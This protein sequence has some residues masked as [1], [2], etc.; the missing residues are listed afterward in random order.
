MTIKISDE[1]TVK[2]KLDALINLNLVTRTYVFLKA[3]KRWLVWLY[4]NGFLD[5]IIEEAKEFESTRYDLPEMDYLIRMSRVEPEKAADILVK[6]IAKMP[7]K[8]I[9]DLVFMD[10]L[11]I[12]AIM[13]AAQLSVILEAIYSTRW[14]SLV[15]IN[16]SSTASMHYKSIFKKL[17]AAKCSEESLRLAEEI[18]AV[19]KKGKT[20]KQN[21]YLQSGDDNFY[22]T[23]LAE[24]GVFHA[25]LSIPNDYVGQAFDLIT[26]VM[27]KI[28]VLSDKSYA[29]RTF[30]ICDNYDFIYF[31]FFE[32]KMNSIERWRTQQNQIMIGALTVSLARK[33][34]DEKSLSQADARI[35]YG[36]CIGDYNKSNARL[37]DTQAMWRLRLF[38][39]SLVPKFFQ[40]KLEESFWRLFKDKYYYDI[41]TGTEYIKALKR[42]FSYLSQ[43]YQTSYVN[44][45]LS[46]FATV[47][48]EAKSQEDITEEERKR[49]I[50][51]EMHIDIGSRILSMI[52]SYLTDEQNRKAEKIGLDITSNYKPETIAKIGPFRSITI[53]G[54]ITY[55]LFAKL[56]IPDIVAK[57]CDEWSMKQINVEHKILDDASLINEVGVSDLLEKDM[58]ERLQEYINEAK[59]FF[60]PQELDLFYTSVYLLGLKT[61]ISK[62]PSLA[63][64][65][66]W[67]QVIE[68]CTTIKDFDIQKSLKEKRIK[69]NYYKSTWESE[70]KELFLKIL[71]FLQSIFSVRHEKNIIDFSKYHTKIL[72][73]LDYFL[74]DE[75]A[76]GIRGRA[77][78]V[79]MHLINNDIAMKR[80][81]MGE[82]IKLKIKSLYKKTLKKEDTRAVMFLFGR[83]LNV[84]YRWDAEWLLSNINLIFSKKKEKKHL[85]TAAWEGFLSGRWGKEM[86]F[87]KEMQ[88][89]YLRGMGLNR[90][91]YPLQKH[92][93]D[94]DELIGERIAWVFVI[95]Y[96]KFR[97][98]DSL[99]INFLESNNPIRYSQFISYIGK[100]FISNSEM[101]LND[102][103]RKDFI[104]DNPEVKKR[105]CKL[106]DWMLSNCEHRKALIEFGTWLSPENKIFE[107]EWLV[108][109]L[110]KTLEKIDGNLSGYK[111]LEVLTKLGHKFPEQVIEI[112]RLCLLG[113]V[114]EVG[115]R[116]FTMYV[117][118]GKWVGLIE[119]IYNSPKMDTE[120]KEKANNLISDLIEKR[121]NVFR[122]LKKLV[123]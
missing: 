17:T 40:D 79:L 6:L 41:S 27:H 33:L 22:F 91:D 46:Y 57:L 74:V 84:I 116:E 100:A 9:R 98:K 24:T 96:K 80:D 12:C 78:E 112:I 49:N 105:L 122:P 19:K 101:F 66:D 86:F 29:G 45:F 99:F 114:D 16:R 50:T 108:D 35:Y 121:G 89:I 42:S 59:R 58:P 13:P 39:L 104:Q 48:S 55:E 34:F 68:L 118:S 75:A 3:D 71:D 70:R 20:K 90:K 82:D 111:L 18:L 28:I 85:F 119:N 107:D 83:Y 88:P 87:E 4:K 102:K 32:L 76:H 23:D 117:E 15:S 69:T 110:L 8:E 93:R 120:L 1:Y 56:S 43:D 62:I 51:K 36:K 14:I 5:I 72:K 44:E 53:R 60:V 37:P 113:E 115:G 30:P 95:Y 11:E 25:L 10:I 21:R 97:F 61:A 106:W 31:D 94:P 123:K 47:I 73:L 64:T 65:C 38:I 2:E 52:K 7:K 63:W 103:E 81:Y 109:R 92:V 77:F 26:K 67:G 54:P